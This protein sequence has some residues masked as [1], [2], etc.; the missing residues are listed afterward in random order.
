VPTKF[1][2][3]R[4]REDFAKW[5]P[6]A[7]QNG[8]NCIWAF[9][10]EDG[11]GL[12]GVLQLY[13]AAE[14]MAIP[15][16]PCSALTTLCH[17]AAPLLRVSDEA[18]VRPTPVA[19]EPV[20]P[21]MAALRPESFR[22]LAGG[23]AEEFGNLLTGVLGHSSLVAAEMGEEHTAIEDVRAI[24]RAARNAAKLTRR[25]SAMSGASHKGGS[26]VDLTAYLR[27]YASAERAE[28]FGGGTELILPEIPCPIHADTVGLE[29]I[30][31]SLAEHAHTAI[32]S[33]TSPSWELVIGERDVVLT[34]SYFGPAALP[35]GWSDGQLPMHSR[36]Q[37]PELLFAREAA[38]ALGG[39]LEVIEDDGTT[40]VQ[41]TL[42]KA[43]QTVPTPSVSEE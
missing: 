17:E 14:D 26:V 10:I 7:E 37:L 3:L 35:V 31:D 13:Y 6:L 8:Y 23:L 29:V 27:H 15:V 24:E 32:M 25:L 41:L 4:A 12:Y 19:P 18:R 11:E 30:F 21:L 42:P 28:Y 16:A 34:L 40:L 20:A 5:V 38:R 1:D 36:N 2:H 39:E 22:M 9:P 33:E 43:V